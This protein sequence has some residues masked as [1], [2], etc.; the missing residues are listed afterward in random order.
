MINSILLVA[1]RFAQDLDS[2]ELDKQLVKR[3]QRLGEPWNA[4]ESL[5]L[6]AS[7][8]SVRS[9]VVLQPEVRIADQQVAPGTAFHGVLDYV[10]G[11]APAEEGT[12]IHYLDCIWT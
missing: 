3:F 11:I 2:P 10:I 1:I 6:T 5:I 12:S 4:T 7:G 8:R 9:W